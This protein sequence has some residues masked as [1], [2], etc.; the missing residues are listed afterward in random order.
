MNYY[1]ILNVDTSSTKVEIKKAYIKLV[2]KYHPDVNPANK[3]AEE[4]L[5]SINNAYDYFKKNDFEHFITMNGRIYKQSY[6]DDLYK[7]Y[8]QKFLDKEKEIKVLTNSFYIVITTWS[9]MQRHKYNFIIFIIGV[10]GISFV[11]S[12]YEIRILG[13]TPFVWVIYSWITVAIYKRKLKKI[14]KK[15]NY[16]IK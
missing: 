14:N 7:Q 1:K 9:I 3:F 11:S 5:K 16:E 6:L 4:K 12:L 10:M 13:Y 2:K 15:Y 8:Y